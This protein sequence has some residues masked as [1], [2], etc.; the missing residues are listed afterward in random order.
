MSHGSIVIA[1]IGDP[2]GYPI[3]FIEKGAAGWVQSASE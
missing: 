3:E 1:F 2:D